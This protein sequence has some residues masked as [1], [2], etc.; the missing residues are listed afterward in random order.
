MAGLRP[1]R[2]AGPSGHSFGGRVAHSCWAAP[3]SHRV[4]VHLP[5]NSGGTI[6]PLWFW[7]RC[8]Q[9]KEDGPGGAFRPPEEGRRPNRKK[10]PALCEATSRGSSPPGSWP[11]L[12]FLED[13]AVDIRR[14]QVSWLPDRPTRGG[15]PGAPAPVAACSAFVPGYSGGSAPGSHRL[16]CPPYGGPLH[17]VDF[18]ESYM[19]YAMGCNTKIPASPYRP[20]GRTDTADAESPPNLIRPPAG[21]RRVSNR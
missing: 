6:P 11:H 12:P 8:F 5:D 4:P 21:I 17:P 10:A 20:A 1:S 19:M 15:L 3:D 9:R 2:A 7:P 14:S 13:A 16:P 18:R